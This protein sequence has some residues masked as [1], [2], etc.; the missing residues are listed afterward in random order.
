MALSLY[1]VTRGQFD[2][3]KSLKTESQSLATDTLPHENGGK[4]NSDKAGNIEN[5]Y[6]T[7]KTLR[8]REIFLKYLGS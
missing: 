1:D 3:P 4:V 6:G 7:F 5:I 8:Q 2:G